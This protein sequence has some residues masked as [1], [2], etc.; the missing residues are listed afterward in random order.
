MDDITTAAFSLLWWEYGLNRPVKAIL[1]LTRARPALPGLIRALSAL[2]QVNGRMEGTPLLE[3]LCEQLHT[4]DKEVRAAAVRAVGVLG[5]VAATEPILTRLAELLAHKD[6]EVRAA[7]VCAVGAL[8][9]AAVAES[10]LTRLAERLD[11]ENMV[12]RKAAAGS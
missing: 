9:G 5:D 11:D 6:R 12:V 2:G 4:T 1:R 7:A 3:W 8:E 10:F